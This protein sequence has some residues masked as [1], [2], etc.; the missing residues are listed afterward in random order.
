MDELERP[1]DQC[2]SVVAEAWTFLDGECTDE[3]YTGMCQ[4]LTTCE[5]C[6]EQIA[7]LGRIKRLIATK[8]GGDSAPGWMKLRR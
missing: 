8:C 6:L 4:H 5:G 7:L 1:S 3:T 2:V